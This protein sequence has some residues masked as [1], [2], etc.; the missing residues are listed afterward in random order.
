MPIEMKNADERIFDE[1]NQTLQK[2]QEYTAECD[3]ILILMQRNAG[4]VM[5]LANS[6]MRLETV[7]YIT[8]SFL[9]KFHAEVSRQ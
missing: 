3:C 6:S 2:A 4:G 7:S 5:Y 8:T 9:H 1:I